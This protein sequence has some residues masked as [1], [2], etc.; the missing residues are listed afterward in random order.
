MAVGLAVFAC[1]FLS[2]TFLV[3]NKCGRRNKFGINRELGGCRMAVCQSVRLALFPAGSSPLCPLCGG[4]CTRGVLQSVC[5]GYTRTGYGAC[6]YE[7]V[8]AG[9]GVV[10][11]V[12]SA[13]WW[14]D[15][16]QTLSGSG[17]SGLCGGW[18][19]WGSSLVAHRAWCWT[20]AR[21]RMAIVP[22]LPP[23]CCL[24]S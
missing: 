16:S 8:G 9:A 10:S 20:G 12:A 18:G 2:T 15:C 23:A 24:A 6:E 17:R 22:P 21:Q 14:L 5:L 4:L 1:L 3:L 7:R 11:E 19:Q 13:N